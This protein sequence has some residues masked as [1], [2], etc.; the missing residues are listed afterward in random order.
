VDLFNPDFFMDRGGLVIFDDYQ[1]ELM[2]N[3]LDNAKPGID[4]FIAA[5]AGQYSIIHFDYQVALVKL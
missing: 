1:L 5:F 2:P 3:P 4:A